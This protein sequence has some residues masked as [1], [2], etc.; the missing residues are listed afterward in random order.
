MICKK[1]G[2]QFE[3]SFNNCPNCGE[4]VNGKKKDKKPVFKKWW[5]W[6]IIAIVLIGI[7]SGA[8]GGA[9]SETT[10]EKETVG[11]SAETTAAAEAENIYKVGEIFNDNG[12]KISFI[13]AE[14]W[15]GYNQYMAPAQGNVIVRYY[16]EVENTADS[17]RSVTYFDFSA[18]CDGKAVEQKYYDGGLSATLSSG[19]KDSGYVYFEVPADAKRIEAEYEYNYWTDGKIIF[20]AEF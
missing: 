5:F 10:T 20:V 8:S 17:D 18:Y 16:F 14:I 9:D 2:Q 3:D 15:N 13:S 11:Q 7:I 1:C 6:L 19:R 4:N 12:L